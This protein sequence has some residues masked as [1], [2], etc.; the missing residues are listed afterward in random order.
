[1]SKRKPKLNGA[2][3]PSCWRVW[4]PD[5]AALDVTLEEFRFPLPVEAAHPQPAHPAPK[6][7]KK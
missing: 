1:M 5:R 6:K 4:A 3:D 7:E 2:L